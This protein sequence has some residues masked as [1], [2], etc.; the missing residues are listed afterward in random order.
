MR[1]SSREIGISPRI[2]ASIAARSAAPSRLPFGKPSDDAL[3]TRPPQRARLGPFHQRRKMDQADLTQCVDGIGGQILGEGLGE[4][5]D[6]IV[7]RR[8]AIG[9]RQRH[10]DGIER[11]ELEDMPGI[12][13][14]GI[15]QPVFDRG[16]GQ[17]Q[18]PCGSRRRRC[19]L[20]DRLTSAGA[21]SAS[22]KST[23]CL[24]A[25]LAASQRASPATAS[26]RCRKREA[27]AGAPPAL[28]E[29]LRITSSVAKQLREVMGRQAD[30]PLRQIETQLVPHRT[31]QPRIGAGRR[32]P[33]AFDQSAGD[34]AV[35]LHQPR[36]QRAIDVERSAGLFG[37]PYC[38]IAERGLE[39]FRVIG[40]R[41]REAALLLAGEQ[42]VEGGCER[43]SLLA[44]RKL[45]RRHR[46]L[47]IGRSALRDGAPRSPPN[48]R[49]ASTRGFPSA[50]EPP[51]RPR[52]APMHGPV[53][54]PSAAPASPMHA[55]TTLPC[56]GILRARCENAKN[57][58]RGHGCRLRSRSAQ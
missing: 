42:L 18:R 43:K 57:P 12:D 36:F 53:P 15:A 32:R 24:P 7:D 38:A 17:F 2:S 44:L 27:T 51:A 31:A 3:E 47:P 9:G 21:S 58:A 46:R 50:R 29:W 14:V 39:H 8:A 5:A 48:H 20:F 40:Q 25:C 11:L 52:S 55:A 22:A 49:A 23:Y 26:S 1:P 41:D 35:G 56:C 19:G 45:R 33:Y 54:G 37:A 28:A 6:R 16:D 13:G 10:V 34:D 30:A 4:F